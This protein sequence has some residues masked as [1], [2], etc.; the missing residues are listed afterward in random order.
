MVAA[1]SFGNA[2]SFTDMGAYVRL[3]GY[4]HHNDA[5]AHVAAG[6]LDQAVAEGRRAW[7]YLPEQTELVIDL[8][9]ALEK[10]GRTADAD[11]LFDERLA[12]MQRLCVQTPRSAG[13]HNGMA[14]VA[15]RCGRRL[16][17]ALRHAKAAVE[18]APTA[19]GYFDT[20]AEVRFQRGEREEALKANEQ[21]IRLAPK[22]AYFAAQRKRIVAGDVKADVPKR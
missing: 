9:R 11:R 6:R 21:A 10:A 5:R 22:D 3:P 4:A 16:D 7:H 19:A 12:L 8:V 14:W 13:R 15:A 17:L 1:V 18:L 2:G 20:L